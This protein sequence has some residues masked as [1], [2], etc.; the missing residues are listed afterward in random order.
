[1]VR[2]RNIENQAAILAL[3]LFLATQGCGQMARPNDRIVLNEHHLFFSAAY[4]ACLEYG[5]FHGMWPGREHD[6]GPRA[7]QLARFYE[8]NLSNSDIAIFMRTKWRAH[9]DEGVVVATMIDGHRILADFPFSGTI[10]KRYWEVEFNNDFTPKKE[11]VPSPSN[12]AKFVAWELTSVSASPIE[13][14]LNEQIGSNPQLKKLLS[15]LSYSAQSDGEDLTVLVRDGESKAIYLF[16][17]R[18]GER[19]EKVQIVSESE[20]MQSVR[21][22]SCEALLRGISPPILP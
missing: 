3:L 6:L 17:D 2:C 16:A 9:Y 21:W 18:A 11:L 4:N 1:M 12:I 7:L 14:R 8:P 22:K 5:R 20:G 13:L 10:D 19:A 15:Q